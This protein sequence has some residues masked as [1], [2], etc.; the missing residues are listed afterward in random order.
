MK[1]HLWLFVGLSLAASVLHA[2]DAKLLSD[3]Y[4]S[5]LRRE[6]IRTHPTA[7]AAN[8]RAQATA[9]D[10]DA[11]RLWD[12]PAVGL[13]LTAAN[14]EM[15]RSNGDVRIGFDQPL[16]RPGLY[17]ARREQADALS[18][19]G[20]EE[21]RTAAL[22]AGAAAAKTATELALLDDSLLLQKEQLQWLAAMAE[23]A[24][25]RTLNPGTTSADALRLESEL[26]RETEI[27]HAAERTRESIAG[28]L[29]LALG[30]SLVSP[31][32]R[33]TLP[34]TPP[35]VPV[36]AAEIARISRVNPTI[37]ALREMASAATA[38]VRVADR[39]RQPQVAVGVESNLY[40]GGE[41]R[42]AM[43]GVKMTLPWGNR[44]AYD[45]ASA[46]AS[47]RASAAAADIEGAR[48]EI[49]SR[50]LAATIEATNDAAQARAF[51]GEIHAKAKLATDS[52]QSSWISSDASLTDLL[53]SNRSLFSIRLAQ[54][55]FLAAQIGALE[56]L[57]LLVPKH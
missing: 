22:N 10:A 24:R 46:A 18:R 47:T 16:P 39:E 2:Q 34:V 9:R 49:A 20:T 1:H 50:I 28:Q 44:R 35:P 40:S 21:A 11:I 5:Q 3:D 6:A 15:R 25:G 36:A 37:L 33:L 54:R 56:D 38:G 41:I 30:R 53:D 4:L 29:N 13:S 31:W 45:A 57:L 23:N 48:R 51:G 19:A 17:A 14:R 42:D 55:R 32:P 27:L 26:A 52:L 43:V 12:D 8:F 7:A